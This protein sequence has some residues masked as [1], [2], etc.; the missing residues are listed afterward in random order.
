MSEAEV[1]RRQFL[2]VGPDC[3]S[4]DH[5]ERMASL[6]QYSR[7][8]ADLNTIVGGK[9][10]LNDTLGDVEEQTGSGVKNTGRLQCLAVP[11]L[12]YE[13]GWQQWLAQES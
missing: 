8:G 4:V 7:K 3:R 9:A 11:F 12:A 1:K 13:Q 10:N 6:G 5:D 2:T